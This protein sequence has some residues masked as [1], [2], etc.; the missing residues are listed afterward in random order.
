MLRIDATDRCHPQSDARTLGSLK[1]CFDI[2]PRLICFIDFVSVRPGKDDLWQ[3]TL[4]P[5]S[6]SHTYRRLDHVQVTTQS[7]QQLSAE[8]VPTVNG[9][10]G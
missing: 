1:L 6:P 8:A 10:T 7:T 3:V 9:L 4:S 5:L 2:V